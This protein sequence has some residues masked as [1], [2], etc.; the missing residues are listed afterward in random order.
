MKKNRILAL[1]LSTAMAISC[2]AFF[3]TGAFAAENVLAQGTWYETIYVEWNG[4]SGEA[5]SAYY[6]ESSQPDSSY[7]KADDPLVRNIS[8]NNYRVDIPG[9]KGNVS[10][11]VKIVNSEGTAVINYTA[12]PVPYDRSG[13]AFDGTSDAPG[14]YKADGTPEDD[15]LIIYLTEENKS[16]VYNNKSITSILG[17][18][19]SL[20]GGKPVILRV[21]G[22]VTPLSS[23]ATSP[24]MWKNTCGVTIE[25][26]GPESGFSGWGIG[27]GDN[28]DTEFRNLNFAD[29]VEDAVGF[30]NAKKLWVHNNTFYSGYN[31]KDSTAE[32]DK[33]HGDGSCD[34]RECDN[35]TVSY[36][37][38]SNTDKTSLIGSSST[39]REST[40]DITFHHN[41]FDGTNQRTP[42]VRWH[43]IHVYNNYYKDTVSYGIGATCNSSIFAENNYF[44]D[45]SSP[46]LTSS[47]GGYA[48]K[49]SDNDGGVIKAYNNV[50]T[51]TRE[52]AEG[53]DYFNAPSREYRMTAADFTTIGGGY[54]YNNFDASGYIASMNYE[55][56]TPEDAKTI[57]LENS[58]AIK[59][60]SIKITD[61]ITPPAVT[62]TPTGRFYYDPETS[63]STGASYGGINGT[64]TYF[65]GAGT[66]GTGSASGYRNSEYYSYSGKFSGAGTISFTTSSNAKFTIIAGS[67]A[68]APVR[69]TLSNSAN[70]DAVYHGTFQTGSKGGSVLTTINLL[71]AGTYSFK[72]ASNV[73]IYYIEVQEFDGADP[74]EVETSTES[75]TAEASTETTTQTTAEPATEANVQNIPLGEAVTGFSSDTSGDTGSG[76][77]VTYNEPTDTW[78]L[79]DSS[80]TAAA[81]LSVPFEEQTN[82][83]V[84]I[85]G[86]VNPSSSSSKWALATIAGTGV[87]GAVKDDIISFAT[88]SNKTL[89]VRTTDSAGTQTHTTI[90][91]TIS[92][93]T[94]Y[95]FRIEIDIDNKSADVTVNGSSVH[96]DGLDVGSVSSFF[97]TTSKKS[98]RNISVANLTVGKVV[99]DTPDDPTPPA[100]KLLGDT[101]VN[102]IITANDASIVLAYTLSPEAAKTVWDLSNDAADVN[103]DTLVTSAD[104]AHI[105]K[106]VINSA[107]SFPKA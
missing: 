101:D 18:F 55:L 107:Y 88:D 57:A 41:F 33:L 29:Y 74:G 14:A 66:C 42:R 11:D 92:A 20:N 51:N 43:N 98:A 103:D 94:D 26:I 100:D 24:G 9:I 17:S 82:G 69:M 6:K 36:N 96:V 47:Q 27:S 22:K 78:Y 19:N 25:G 68:S 71:E 89:C 7:V 38:F 52:S 83:T 23:S 15:A 8:A 106:K 1:F 21:V 3:T 30:E 84:V 104:A 44:E 4:A 77:S 76:I 50:M 40:G 53:I 75:T 39:S 49:F 93:N 12:T 34:L 67:S 99:E 90:G 37:H 32:R 48:S 87:N 81:T 16:S 62:G 54:T 28:S 86:T 70:E 5:Y 72:P 2:A 56:N 85:K 31:P 59:T 58:G 105:M 64:G 35:V 13:F 46:F 95:T 97:T 65:S 45:A 79:T 63:G 10:Y 80:T 60:A 61:E 91:G 102:G 73:D